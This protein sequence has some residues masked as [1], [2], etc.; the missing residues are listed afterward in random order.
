ML[1]NPEIVEM[2]DDSVAFEEGCLSFPRIFADVKVNALSAHDASAA[3]G[4]KTA[5]QLVTPH[6]Q[7]AQTATWLMV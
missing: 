1:I 7:T 3:A 2:S 5:E 4:H 6:A